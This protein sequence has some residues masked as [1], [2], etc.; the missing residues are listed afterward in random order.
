MTF[1]DLRERSSLATLKT[2]KVLKTLTVLKAFRSPPPPLT[3]VKS[4][5]KIDID[6]TPPSSQFILSATY[7]FGP[8]ASSLLVNSPIKIQVN[9]S[10][11]STVNYLVS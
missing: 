6:T 5:S 9:H 7:F 8:I 3:A 10:F 11:A 1:M 2:L 4:I